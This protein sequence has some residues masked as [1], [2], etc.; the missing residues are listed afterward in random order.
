MDAYVENDNEMCLVMLD[1]TLRRV[2]L[3]CG[4]QGLPG[5]SGSTGSTGSTG[6]CGVGITR[7]SQDQR[8]MSMVVRLSNGQV[9]RLSL[10]TGPQGPAGASAVS[11]SVTPEGCLALTLDNGTCVTTSN[12]LPRGERGATGSTGDPGSAGP[13]G[14]GIRRLRCVR[15]TLVSEM[16]DGSVVKL[17]FPPGP[18]GP[19]ARGI[20][21]IKVDVQQSTDFTE[22]TVTLHLQFT[23]ST[24]AAVPIT[25]S[26][27]AGPTGP[28]T[29]VC[30]TLGAAE[31]AQGAVVLN[32]HPDAL[33][34]ANTG[35][36]VRP[37]K[38]AHTKDA[39]H[40]HRFPLFYDPRT[41]EIVAVLDD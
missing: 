29:A 41:H 26:L 38:I 2:R 9:E 7:I 14:I 15:D 12:A 22:A 40:D 25:L 16:S 30:S 19:R 8:T 37:V 20:E 27:P 24:T 23:D 28:S 34:V 39:A 3:P 10:P 6:A 5:L 18:T 1:G 4:P 13:P 33:R 31:A 11:A 35:F 32:G 21:D 36:Y 17:P